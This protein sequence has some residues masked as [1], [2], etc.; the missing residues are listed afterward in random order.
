MA[1]NKRS[2]WSKKENKEI[3]EKV[4]IEP[5]KTINTEVDEEIKR[6]RDEIR[7]YY[8]EHPEKDP[9]LPDRI[10][11]K[12]MNELEEK[13]TEHI[14]KK[15]V[16]DE[17][18]IKNIIEQEEG[19][20]ERNQKA[21]PLD[22][23]RMRQYDMP[24]DYVNEVFMPEEEAREEEQE[25][26]KIVPK[27]KQQ[28]EI[29]SD[30]LGDVSFGALKDTREEKEKKKII[31]QEEKEKEKKK[32]LLSDILGDVSF[33]QIQGIQEEV[34]N[35][36]YTLETDNA[37]MPED[38]KETKKPIQG[39]AKEKETQ[40]IL[41]KMLQTGSLE[42]KTA[43]HTDEKK[44]GIKGG[45]KGGQL[46]TAPT[47][48]VTNTDV[49]MPEVKNA[50]SK[51]EDLLPD[52]TPKKEEKAKENQ[53]DDTETKQEE[54]MTNTIFVARSKNEE[55]TKSELD[56][57]KGVDKKKDK[58][59][60]VEKR[61]ETKTITEKLE[62]K[63]YQIDEEI[64]REIVEVKTPA[65]TSTV[66]KIGKRTEQVE[67]KEKKDEKKADTH[68]VNS[69]NQTD[70]KTTSTHVASANNQ[71]EKPEEVESTNNKLQELLSGMMHTQEPSGAEKIVIQ[72][73]TAKTEKSKI[74]REWAE[75]SKAEEVVKTK[76][77]DKQKSQKDPAKSGQPDKQESQKESAK[78]EQVDKQ[79]SQKKPAKTEQ[80]DKQEQQKKPAKTEQTDKQESQKESVQSENAEKPQQESANSKN[81]EKPQQESPIM[82][83]R[84]T[85][86]E[87][88]VEIE[89]VI[90]QEKTILREEQIETAVKV[91]AKSAVM[92]V[93]NLELNKGEEAKKIGKIDEQD[94]QKIPQ[95]SKK[96]EKKDTVNVISATT[97]DE[98]A[99]TSVKSMEDIIK[100]LSKEQETVFKTNNTPPIEDVVKAISN[101]PEVVPKKEERDTAK[102]MADVTIKKEDTM[103]SKLEEAIEA[104]K[105]RENKKPTEET[106]KP[107]GRKKKKE[108]QKKVVAQKEKAQTQIVESIEVK[109]QKVAEET[110][111]VKREEKQS[112]FARILQAIQGILKPKKQTKEREVLP[113]EQKTYSHTTLI[114]QKGEKEEI[115]INGVVSGSIQGENII[116]NPNAVVKNDIVASGVVLC[117]DTAT[118]MGSVKGAEIVIE[119]IIRGDVYGTRRVFVKD[120][121]LVAGNIYGE[122]V[123]VEEQAILHGSIHQGTEGQSIGNQQREDI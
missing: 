109:T 59:K 104:R 57:A 116:V 53:Q 90:T 97:E 95:A 63:E 46:T 115:Q 94:I 91:P 27:K 56:G 77:S 105:L 4:K 117:M 1:K 58:K 113:K 81:K 28:E 45:M 23:S 7:T 80:A 70:K 88:A 50:N 5:E 42:E 12:D 10:F 30:I 54:G 66:E 103:K 14:P 29:L 96:I 3:K 21:A 69:S 25:Q 71:I 11:V 9:A 31:P 87:T 122:V 75:P 26:K 123:Y 49:D 6:L 35:Q 101:T 102:E 33:G 83:E 86:L 38:T 92:D 32:E 43:I 64:E 68:E 112:F 48:V 51:L 98:K 18:I 110:R 44:D 121:A 41:N 100:A 52:T 62:I 107:Q 89:E 82:K 67:S 8:L 79:E 34:T 78:S 22:F 16:E 118:I 114:P 36:I 76:Q 55:E 74:Q 111:I 65:W 84:E 120:G 85:S 13:I 73:E 40:D 37:V 24:K 39:K 17:I 2:F 20:G 47:P 119:G 61:Q 106:N 108:Q 93:L 72:K 99:N 19:I 60:P 15:I